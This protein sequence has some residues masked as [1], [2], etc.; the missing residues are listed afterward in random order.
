MQI[1]LHVE[2]DGKINH[3]EPG[4]SGLAVRAVNVYR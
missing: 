4:L 3:G 1:R 2:A